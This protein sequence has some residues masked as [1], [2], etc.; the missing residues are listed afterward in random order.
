MTKIDLRPDQWPDQLREGREKTK[1]PEG[2]I[3]QHLSLPLT[4]KCA[5][6]PHQNV[7]YSSSTVL[8][9]KKGQPETKG[10]TKLLGKG[11]RSER[12]EK[13]CGR[14]KEGS[15]FLLGRWDLITPSQL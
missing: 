12:G 9:E 4:L 5:S 7:V 1:G 15:T 14:K 13:S 3:L 10:S 8:V 11:Q 2:P 6:K